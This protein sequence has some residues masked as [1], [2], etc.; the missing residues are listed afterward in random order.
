MS[1]TDLKRVRRAGLATAGLAALTLVSAC[2]SG[3]VY[4]PQTS[5]PS[6]PQVSGP[7]LLSEL[8]G[9]VAVREAGSRTEQ[10]FR[11]AL[12]FRLNGSEPVRDARYEVNYSITALDAVTSVESGSGIP[13]AASYRMQAD[14]TI[15]RLSDG[16]TIGAGSRFSTVPYDRNS[17][18][19]AS[20]SA[21]E[22]ARSR[23]GK[24]LAERVGM[25]LLPVLKR[26]PGAGIN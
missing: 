4:A 2:T 19:Y 6:A 21:V 26:E 1:S 8:R 10:I 3:P 23:A 20:Q 18:L 22:D 25:A 11:N 5:A 24:E 12:L 13:S 14:Y 15:I 16:Q 7:P 17:Q 9:R